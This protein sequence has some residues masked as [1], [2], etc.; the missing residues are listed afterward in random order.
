MR[1]SHKS[2]GLGELITSEALP[3]DRWSLVLFEPFT[4]YRYSVSASGIHSVWGEFQ[5]ADASPS[6]NPQL[7]ALGKALETLRREF[8]S[9]VLM[10]DGEPPEYVLAYPFIRIVSRYGVAEHNGGLFSSRASL[11]VL[12][13]DIRA[14]ASL[15]YPDIADRPQSQ[16]PCYSAGL[17]GMESLD[18]GVVAAEFRQAI[19]IDDLRNRLML[20]FTA[21]MGFD[22][23]AFFTF[24]TKDE[25]VIADVLKSRV[26]VPSAVSKKKRW[27]FQR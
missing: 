14:A 27:F 18:L 6:P 4:C 5:W 20:R 7:R 10:V 2:L 23:D 17:Y 13:V 9:S 22:H 24:E 15:N 26:P 19:S 21:Y 3:T 12:L 16:R 1:S 8:A 11:T 25:G